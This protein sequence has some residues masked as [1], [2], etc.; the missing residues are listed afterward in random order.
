CGDGSR[1]AA[2]PEATSWLPEE[3]RYI[4]T[5]AP[6]FVTVRV[7][8]LWALEP[9]KDVPEELRQGDRAPAWGAPTEFAQVLEAE[10]GIHPLNVE[11]LSLTMLDFPAAALG[12]KQDGLFEPA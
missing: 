11:R 8:D 7:G 5:E 6:G 4:P 10:A 3:L 2:E 9:W 12:G 1:T